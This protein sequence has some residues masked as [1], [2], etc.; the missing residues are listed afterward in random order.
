MLPHQER[1]V[2]EQNILQTRLDA[3][4]AFFETET[5]KTMEPVSASQLWHQ[6]FHMQAY[7]DI[8]KARIS[9]F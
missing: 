5:Y 9:G 6:A 3:L 4:H 7:N 1:V 8:L 2:D